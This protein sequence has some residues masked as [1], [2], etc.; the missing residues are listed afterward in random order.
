MHDYAANEN[1][2][3]TERLNRESIQS[4]VSSGSSEFF[5]KGLRECRP[6]FD[7]RFLLRQCLPVQTRRTDAA[8]TRNTNQDRIIAALVREA[9]S[10]SVT[11]HRN[12]I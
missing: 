10:I 6:F 9:L 3:Q 5:I 8:H 4:F 12:E 1:F 7:G 11:G 2:D